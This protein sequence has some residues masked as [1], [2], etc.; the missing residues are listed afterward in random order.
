MR[1]ERRRKGLTM[2]KLADLSGISQPFLSQLENGHHMPSIIT[3]HKIAHILRV[4]ARDFLD[5]EDAAEQQ[6]SRTE[7]IQLVRAHE[8]S[9]Y[10]LAPGSR[11]RFLVHGH[12][13]MEPNE[14]IAI[15]GSDSSSHTEHEGEEF[16]YLLS[17]SLRVTLGERTE[18][19]N[20]GDFIYYPAQIPH[21]WAC[22]GNV[23]AHFIITSSPSSF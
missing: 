10:E 7:S 23:S 6:P 3:L 19:L 13:R 22:E 21:S 8:R 17:G 1:E 14:V 18:V 9:R 2:Q 11:V 16:I 15:P 20:E 4:N 12:T 5:S